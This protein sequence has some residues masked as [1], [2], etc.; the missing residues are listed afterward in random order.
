[1][2]QINQ[3]RAVARA[4]LFEKS[5]HLPSDLEKTFA[6]RFHRQTSG[7]KAIGFRA[8]NGGKLAQDRSALIEDLLLGACDG[9]DKALPDVPDKS[10]CAINIGIARQ[11]QR[12]VIL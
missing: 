12:R 8:A 4:D 9:I 11:M 6:G 2:P 10:D 5:G 7:G 3:N 1:V